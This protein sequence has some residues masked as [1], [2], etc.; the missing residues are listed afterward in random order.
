MEKVA[1]TM[2]FD[3]MPQILSE[4]ILRAELYEEPWPHILIRDALHA[5]HY[6]R[7]LEY[8]ATRP[9]A[10]QN[11]RLVRYLIAH[12]DPFATAVCS[13]AVRAALKERLG[14]EGTGSPRLVCDPPDYE[15]KIHTDTES[16]AG[17][18]QIYITRTEVPGHGTKLWSRDGTEMVKEIPFAPNVGYAFK[19]LPDS[20]HSLG[21]M[22]KD[23]W[24]LLCPYMQ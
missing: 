6:A 20:W 21:P 5:I 23:R 22:E 12:K 14:F 3:S 13:H 8:T 24:S 11:G 17:T 4:S 1:A 15:S 19:K 16:K 9:Q 2:I 7:L 10:N 18:L